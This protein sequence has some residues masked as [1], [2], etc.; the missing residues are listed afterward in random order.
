MTEPNM[1]GCDLHDPLLRLGVQALL[2][3]A[4]AG[5]VDWSQRRP[6]CFR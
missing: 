1:I 5:A 3:V 4:M 2:T 6:P